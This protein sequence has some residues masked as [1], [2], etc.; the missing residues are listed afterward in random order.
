MRTFF[1]C[2]GRGIS[3][4]GRNILFSVAS[5][6]TVAACIF[7]FCMFFSIIVNVQSIVY[8]AETTVGMTVFF[9]EDAGDEEKEAVYEAILDYGGVKEINYISA[10]EAWDTFKTEYFGEDAEELAAA[11]ADDNPLANSDSYEVFPE[12][13]EQQEAMVEFI[14]G[15]EGV[16][17][18]NYADTVVSVLKSLNRVISVLSVVVIGVL[19]AVSAF[20]IS[21]TISVT[22]AFRKRENE[23]MRLIGATNFM[24]RAPFIVEGV[25]IGAL[26]SAI[27]LAAFYLIYRRILD[28][29]SEWLL[30]LGTRSDLLGIVPLSDILDRLLVCG[31]CF[32]VG[33]G[34]F[35][36]FFTIRKHLKV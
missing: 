35:V 25:M 26:G 1:Y 9:E 5:V 28:F 3:N 7:L 8:T 16:R 36:S 19:V 29:F 30:G 33:M 27:P 4:L 22:A 31:L 12:A 24:I 34:F 6:S 21:N 10:D 15:L 20:L 32:G 18:V 13:I 11:F 17:E 14:S 23:I 2:I